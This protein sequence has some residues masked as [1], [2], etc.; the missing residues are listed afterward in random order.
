MRA[1]DALELDSD[2]DFAAVKAAYRRLAK[3]NHPDLKPGDA[4]AAQRFQ[5][6]KAAYDVL[7]NAEERREAALGRLAVEHEGRAAERDRALRVAAMGDAADEGDAA[8]QFLAF[9]AGDDGLALGGGAQVIEPQ[10]ERHHRR[11]AVR[12][13]PRRSA[14]WRCRS[15]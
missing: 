9:A 12:A 11:E 4:E 6:V 3:E 10:V 1:L 13:S 14:R 2:A 5:K 8:G 15:G 7:R